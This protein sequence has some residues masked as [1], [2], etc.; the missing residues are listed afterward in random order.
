[1]AGVEEVLE[2]ATCALLNNFA[3]S[4]EIT[5]KSDKTAPFFEKLPSEIRV[6]I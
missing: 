1:M 4:L 2:P 5:P 6:R 3:A